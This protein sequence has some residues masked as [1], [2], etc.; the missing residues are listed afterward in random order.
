MIK[1]GQKVQILFEDGSRGDAFIEE[2]TDEYEH[3]A[4]A[5][6]RR[7]VLSNYIN[8]SN[9]TSSNYAIKQED[10]GMETRVREMASGF[11]GTVFT[12]VDGEL[13][14]VADTKPFKSAEK[15]KAAVKKL[16]VAIAKKS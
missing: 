1:P 3:V 2:Y 9:T 13:V 7:Y 16:A 12:K 10:S 14:P 4:N 15:A 5:F 8:I 11:V 6:K